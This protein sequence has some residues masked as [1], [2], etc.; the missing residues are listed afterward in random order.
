MRIGR[1]IMIPV[2]FTIAAAGLSLAGAPAPAAAAQLSSVHVLA[3]GAA[4]G[5]HGIYYHT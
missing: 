4:M 1:A 3:Q 5:E 2:V